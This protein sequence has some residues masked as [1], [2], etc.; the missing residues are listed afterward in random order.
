M[1]KRLDAAAAPPSGPHESDIAEQ[2][3]HWLA[4]AEDV[5]TP[6][7]RVELA[8]FAAALA[9][10]M[11]SSPIEMH[12]A[13][14]HVER[15]RCPLYVGVRGVVIAESAHTVQLVSLEGGDGPRVRTIPTRGS[16]FSVELPGALM[17]SLYA[18]GMPSLQVGF[19][20][21]H[22]HAAE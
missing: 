2:H 13:M 18:K 4:Y 8:H 15:S 14:L 21:S 22:G 20:A 17:Q 5:L 3:K 7:S 9:R 1:R 19:L 11:R 16:V 12:G 6:M 10:G